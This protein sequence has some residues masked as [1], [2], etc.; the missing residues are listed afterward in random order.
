MSWRDRKTPWA[1]VLEAIGEWSP[2]NDGSYEA[3]TQTWGGTAD[4]VMDSVI[5]GL[6]PARGVRAATGAARTAPSWSTRGASHAAS[7]KGGATARGVGARSSGKTTSGRSPRGARS[8]SKAKRVTPAPSDR[9][10]MAA[11]LGS[12]GV[13]GGVLT[14]LQERDT[15]SAAGSRM[16]VDHSEHPHAGPA[17]RRGT[18]PAEVDHSEHP[19]AGPAQGALPPWLAELLGEGDVDTDALEQS[20]DDQLAALG[21]A[22]EQFADLTEEQKANIRSSADDAVGNIGGFFDY[23]AHQANQGRPV[24]AETGANTQGELDAIYDELG[25]NLS[26]IP[27]LAGEQATS[28]AGGAGAQVGTRMEAAAAP[29]RAAGESARASSK[30]NVAQHSAAGQD[31]LSQ[32]A[33]AA[34]AEGAMGQQTVEQGAAQAL[35][36]ADMALAEQ[37]MNL[38]LETARLEGAKQRALLEATSDTAGSTFD[39][40]MQGAQLIDAVG[41]D[42]GVLRDALGV[43]AAPTAAGAMDPEQMLDLA[44][45]EARLEDMTAPETE[46]YEGF[47]NLLAQQDPDVQAHAQGLLDLVD[48]QGWQQE[49][50]KVHQLIGQLTTEDEDTSSWWQG[51]NAPEAESWDE[52]LED[53]DASMYAPYDPAI[54]RHLFRTL[55]Q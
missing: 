33:A 7:S 30:G 54:L 52:L 11:I 21:A 50:E 25:Q 23:A 51:S 15:A 13:T 24:I 31:Y 29:F 34:P 38:E 26:T 32:L 1:G 55:Y 5:A 49:P 39:R 6:A 28:A 46:G 4:A 27:G 53:P 35:T 45:K 18:G 37:Q 12:L 44:I 22:G 36:N 41:G 10:Q 43:P 16:Q 2:L 48:T 14:G 40:F 19:H 42:P 47:N 8:A 17:Q 9:E 3:P 20:Y